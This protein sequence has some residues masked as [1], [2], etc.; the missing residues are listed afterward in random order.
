MVVYQLKSSQENRATI[1]IFKSKRFPVGI[2]VYSNVGGVRKVKVSEAGVEGSEKKSQMTLSWSTG[3]QG[4]AGACRKTQACIPHCKGGMEGTQQRSWSW[5]ALCKSLRASKQTQEGLRQL[6]VSGASK[7]DELEQEE[8]TGA[9]HPQ[10]PLYI[11]HSWSPWHSRSSIFSSH[12]PSESH[13]SSLNCPTLSPTTQK[14][15][16]WEMLVSNLR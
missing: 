9:S 1:S 5:K 14:R 6:W 4:Q 12:L 16:F 11:Y 3:T 13:E 2:W 15:G 10:A 7:Q 8:R